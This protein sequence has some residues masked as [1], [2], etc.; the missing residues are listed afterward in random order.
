MR[1]ILF[2]L[3]IELLKMKYFFLKDF[4]VDEDDSPGK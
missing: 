3:F 2:R 1:Y 4:V